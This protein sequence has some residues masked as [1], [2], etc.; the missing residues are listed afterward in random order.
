MIIRMVLRGGQAKHAA[1]SAKRGL[2]TTLS[3]AAIIGAMLAT[4]PAMAQDSKKTAPGDTLLALFDQA[5]NGSGDAHLP[6]VLNSLKKALAGQNM[7]AFLKLVDPAYFTEQF[8]LMHRAGRSPGESLGQ[9]ACEFFSVCDI[10]KSY[11][12]NDIVSAH[13]LSAKAKPGAAGGLIEVKLELR[14]W[15]GLKLQSTIFY[16]P[17]NARLSAARG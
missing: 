10:S 6:Y 15:D 12:F 9:F 16:D 3:L 4:A 17:A 8:G 1:A 13:V 14:M 2:L 5:R 7:L 11:S